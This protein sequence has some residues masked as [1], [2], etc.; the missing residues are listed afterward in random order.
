[1]K[2]KKSIPPVLLLAAET[3]IF[4]LLLP[5]QRQIMRLTLFAALLL[6]I[7]LCYIAPF[8]DL[9]KPLFVQIRRY[10]LLLVLGAGCLLFVSNAAVERARFYLLEERYEQAVTEAAETLPPQGFSILDGEQT[11]P[12][13]A[14]GGELHYGKSE[15][16]VQVYF[17][18]LYTFFQNT[19]LFFTQ[20]P[21]TLPDELSFQE[22]SWFNDHWAYVKLY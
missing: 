22:V 2:L 7:L 1:M 15:E 8:Y 10:V 20:V 17:K 3:L 18:D 9:P 6:V 11:A 14:Q 12:Y 4:L 5:Q 19:G 13:L 21:K 16:N